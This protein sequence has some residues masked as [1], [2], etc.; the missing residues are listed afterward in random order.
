MLNPPKPLQTRWYDTASSSFLILFIKVIKLP[1]RENFPLSACLGPLCLTSPGR[2][3]HLAME[4]LFITSLSEVAKHKNQSFGEHLEC[5]LTMVLAIIGVKKVLA[6]ACVPQGLEHR[7]ACT[8]GL[9]VQ[10]PV[11]DLYLGC[12]L[13]PQPQSLHVGSG[14]DS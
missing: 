3:A 14:R 8:K 12:K 6:L 5:G 4:T 13:D 1:L 2:K 9:W 7:P 10:C 11:K